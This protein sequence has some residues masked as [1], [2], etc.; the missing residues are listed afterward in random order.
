[1]AKATWR[2]YWGG[3][4]MVIKV[5]GRRV[6]LKFENISDYG[7]LSECGKVIT[8]NKNLSPDDMLDTIIHEI[9]HVIFSV[10]GMPTECEETIVHGL[11][12]GL[13][14]VLIDNPNLRKTINKLASS[15]TWFR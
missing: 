8:I 4:E 6:K 13:T 1:M 10:T 2:I 12:A 5:L 9:L 3:F 14:T 7:H 15:D 11:S